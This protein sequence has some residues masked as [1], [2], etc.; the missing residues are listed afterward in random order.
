MHPVRRG[1]ALRLARACMHPV[2]RAARHC[3]RGHDLRLR[4]RVAC[5]HATQLGTYARL[6]EEMVAE[7]PG[8]G[9]RMQEGDAPRR[10][11]FLLVLL[12]QLK[13]GK[14]VWALERTAQKHKAKATSSAE[15]LSRTPEGLETPSYEV[16]ASREA[17]GWEVSSRDH[18]IGVFVPFDLSSPPRANRHHLAYMAGAPL[19]RVCSVRD[20]P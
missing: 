19:R 16:I 5:C 1:I 11:R 4:A 9:G 8:S 7:E 12:R 14:G 18:A 6:L 20:E 15:M 3:S 13:A 2:N 17:R 10:R